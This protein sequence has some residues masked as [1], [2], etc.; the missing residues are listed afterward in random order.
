MII[1]FDMSDVTKSF[2][3]KQVL[4]GATLKLPPGTVTGLL[5]TNGA[6]KTTLLKCA[7]GLLRIQSG[8]CRIFGESSWDLSAETKAR[9]GY[10]PQIPALWPWIK[11][12]QLIEY[13][14]SFYARW[15]TDKIL[16]LQ[17]RWELKDKDAVGTL[18][19]GQMQR[20][21]IL[22]ALGHSPELLILD[23]PAASLDPLARRQFLE[24]IIDM[25]EPGGRT[26]LFS[27]HIV[28]DLE[29]VADS[30]AVL[31]NGKVAFHGLVDELKERVRRVHVTAPA[32][33][34]ASLDLPGTLHEDIRGREA[35]LSL[36][37]ASEESLS[38]IRSKFSAEVAVQ[39]LNLEEI[40]LEMHHV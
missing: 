32:S 35:T 13:T 24:L 40:F 2:G 25:A 1:P 4:D 20:L 15:D 22:L 19:T 5:G 36:F 8:E 14:A 26:V 12:G 23:E 39:E 3:D 11:V 7:L 33:L 29:R 18:S 17:K 10:V 34:P 9:I 38:A 16:D 21:A 30:V 27:T 37:G 31:R 28:S 6:G